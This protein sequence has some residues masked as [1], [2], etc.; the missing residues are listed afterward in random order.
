LKNEPGKDIWLFGGG[1]PMFPLPLPRTKLTL[2]S[3]RR[4]E[5]SGIVLLEYALNIS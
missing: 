3:H 5:K 1:V 4:F 2:R